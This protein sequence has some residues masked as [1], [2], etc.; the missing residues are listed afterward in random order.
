MKIAAGKNR[1][2]K[3]DQRCAER[4]LGAVSL[5]DLKRM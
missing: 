3:N 4:R 2:I 5:A 1:R